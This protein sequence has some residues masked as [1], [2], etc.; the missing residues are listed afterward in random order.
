MTQATITGDI[1]IISENG[2]GSETIQQARNIYDSLSALGV[3]PVVE[4]VIR[5]AHVETKQATIPQLP[6]NPTT[7][8]RKKV[9]RPPKVKPNAAAE[10]M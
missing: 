10:S 5:T 7:P 4:I 1:R 3:H 8:L 2:D 6:A 9:G